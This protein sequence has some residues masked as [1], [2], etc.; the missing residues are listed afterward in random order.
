M[1]D[2]QLDV[3]DIPRISPKTGI[4]ITKAIYPGVVYVAKLGESSLPELRDIRSELVVK[5]IYSEIA[6][7]RYGQEVHKFL[8]SKDMAP[9][10]LTSFFT[11]LSTLPLAKLETYHVMEYLSPPVGTS[12]GWITLHELGKKFP[13][14]A[15]R[16]KRQI[17]DALYQIIDVLQHEKLVHGDLRTNNVLVQVRMSEDGSSVLIQERPSDSSHISNRVAYLKV[18]DFD[19][20]GHG[21]GV[22]YPS[23]RNPAISWPGENGKAIGLEDDRAMINHWLTFWPNDPRP[24]QVL[25]NV[26]YGQ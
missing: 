17:Q 25:A 10:Y 19:W 13:K 11:K 18:V 12:L 1:E 21:T 5:I 7:E 6:K 15:I 26:E 23:V 16:F 8:A 22:L 24:V 2:S 9:C 14:D 20:A 3:K 4:Q